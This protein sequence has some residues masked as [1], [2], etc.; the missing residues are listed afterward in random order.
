MKACL[1]FSHEVNLSL[2]SRRVR[3]QTRDDRSTPHLTLLRTTPP[4]R[5]TQYEF[6]CRARLQYLP[7]HRMRVRDVG[8]GT[9]EDVGQV[10]GKDLHDRLV[11]P[12]L[13]QSLALGLQP[14]R[15]ET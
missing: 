11:D 3:Y 8:F 15:A 2:P 14:V 4:I 6:D 5:V 1:A 9:L 10:I 13:W 7:A 12:N